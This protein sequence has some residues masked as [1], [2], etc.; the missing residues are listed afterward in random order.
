MFIRRVA[1][2]LRRNTILI[3]VCL[4]VALGGAYVLT[5]QQTP[6]YESTVRVVV[7][8]A[9]APADAAESDGEQ[10]DGS[11]AG[12]GPIS[13]VRRGGHQPGARQPGRLPPARRPVLPR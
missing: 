11:G 3:L 2:A 1:R 7:S 9:A 13:D 4:A 12:A 8:A 6:R 10:N 5:E